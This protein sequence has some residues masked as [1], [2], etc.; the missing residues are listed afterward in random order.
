MKRDADL[1]RTILLEVEANPD[2]QSWIDPEPAGYTPEQISYHIML[3]DQAGLIEGWDRSAIGI[4]RW[5]ARNLT[6]KGHE[7]VEAA[8]SEEAW[9]KT[10]STL[11]QTTG[12]QVFELLSEL[13]V[14]EARKKTSVER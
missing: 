1:I 13:L 6:W 7:V 8:R 9:A 11:A 5:S 10:K 14:T 4:F 2:P 12:G 3:M